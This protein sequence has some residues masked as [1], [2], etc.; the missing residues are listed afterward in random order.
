MV[1]IEVRCHFAVV[2]VCCLDTVLLHVD[3]LCHCHSLSPSALCFSAH[4]WFSCFSCNHYLISP[5]LCLDFVPGVSSHVPLQIVC[6]TPCLSWII[7]NVSASV[8]VC[9][10]VRHLRVLLNVSKKSLSPRSVFLAPPCNLSD[11]LIVTV[12]HFRFVFAFFSF[13]V[14]ITKDCSS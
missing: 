10:C 5:H 1:D 8:S 6:S 3:G 12:I 9:T 13:S 7:V 4:V 11:D 14:I 2:S